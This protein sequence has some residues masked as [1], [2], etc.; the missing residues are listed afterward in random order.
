VS[1]YAVPVPGTVATG[2]KPVHDA[3]ARCTSVPLANGLEL[4][5]HESETSAA[6]GPVWLGWVDVTF[7]G[8]WRASAFVAADPVA[9][10]PHIASA[11]TAPAAIR[12]T[13]RALRRPG[14]RTGIPAPAG[15][16]WEPVRLSE[17]VKVTP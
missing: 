17:T 8:G 7:V 4:G 14:R 12:T 10:A 9:L 6:D 5:V 1:V 13:T 11:L 16:T 3:G 15:Y 2:A